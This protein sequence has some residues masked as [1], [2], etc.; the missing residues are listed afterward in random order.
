MPFEGCQF[1]V[2]RFKSAEPSGDCPSPS[3]MLLGFDRVVVL[4]LDCK[5]QLALAWFCFDV[6]LADDLG[7]SEAPFLFIQREF[8]VKFAQM[9]REL[10]LWLRFAPCQ[11]T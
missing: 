2:G 10:F 5:V 9:V 7:C 1:R 8:W 6:S 4:S 3:E 11:G